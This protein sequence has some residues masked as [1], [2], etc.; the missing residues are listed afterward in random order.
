MIKLVMQLMSY[1]SHVIKVNIAYSSFGF[2]S[3]VM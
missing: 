2:V 1:P 3:N